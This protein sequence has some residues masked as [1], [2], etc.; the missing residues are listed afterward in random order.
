MIFFL[1][2]KSLPYYHLLNHKLYNS[3]LP[4]LLCIVPFSSHFYFL[5]QVSHILLSVPLWLF[6]FLILFLIS[7]LI[8]VLLL[9]KL[10][11]LLSSFLLRLL[12]STIVPFNTSFIAI[13]LLLHL[14]FYRFC[15]LCSHSLLLYLLHLT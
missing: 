2:L 3:C 13:N 4:L 7:I 10:S 5:I 14:H 8:L 6:S 9:V 12:C 11:R 1:L 15:I